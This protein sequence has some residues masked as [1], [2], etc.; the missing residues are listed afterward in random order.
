LPPSDGR[1]VTVVSGLVQHGQQTIVKAHLLAGSFGR[2]FL[3]LYASIYNS[4]T[5]KS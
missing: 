2:T 4:L 5:I 3:L 1:V